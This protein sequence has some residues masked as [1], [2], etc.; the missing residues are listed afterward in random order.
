MEKFI[1]NDEATLKKGA[2]QMITFNKDGDFIELEAK[3]ESTL[4]V[5]SGEPINEK[6]AQYG[7][8]VMNTQTELLEAMRDYQQGKMGFLY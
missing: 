6:V 5:L 7:P 8:Y 3:Q 2:A 1:V 4:L